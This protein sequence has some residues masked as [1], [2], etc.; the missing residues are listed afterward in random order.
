MFDTWIP[1]YLSVGVGSPG[2]LLA[3]NIVNSASPLLFGLYPG[4]H[5]NLLLSLVLCLTFNPQLI[6]FHF[7][8]CFVLVSSG[9][10][11]KTMMIETRCQRPPPEVP[12]PTPRFAYGPPFLAYRGGGGDSP[13]SCRVPPGPWSFEPPIV[14]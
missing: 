14:P 5:L 9:V 13:M 12:E 10:H 6:Q 3:V 4:Q 2:R 1:G 11:Q 8:L 7:R